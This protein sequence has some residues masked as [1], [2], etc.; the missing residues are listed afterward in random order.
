M[1]NTISSNRL[2]DVEEIKVVRDESESN[3]LLDQ[4]WILLS[5]GNGQEQTYTHSFYPTFAYCLGKIRET[6]AE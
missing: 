2:Q 5:V 3:E 1:K 4:G 6:E